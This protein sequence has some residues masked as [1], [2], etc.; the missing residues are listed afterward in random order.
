MSAGF[1]VF[2]LVWIGLALIL[3]P[4]QV[5]LVAPYGRHARGGWGPVVGNR[6]GWVVMEAV[7]PLAFLL[8]FVLLGAPVE[9]AVWVFAALWCLHYLNRTLIYPL[10]T[11]TAG[12]TMP[13]VIMAS[14]V[15]FNAVNGWINGQYLAAGW[16]G[17]GADWLRDPRFLCGLALFAL[18]AG[19]NLWADRRLVRLRARGGPQ[20]Y[21]IPQ[22]GMFRWVSC[23][24]HLGEIIEWTGFAI[25]CWNLPALA[26]AVWTAANL[27]PRALA[28]HCWYRARFAD[29]PAGRR[30]LV[31]FLL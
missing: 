16:G 24:N 18:G 23:P 11:R 25:A 9:A 1:Q 29:Y 17:Y 19:L 27:G 8:P 2:V 4:V 15:A 5:R 22:G 13:L 12:K 10:T 30:A 28:H 6:L 3:V 26:F 14:A 20:H 31:P 21:V 7:S